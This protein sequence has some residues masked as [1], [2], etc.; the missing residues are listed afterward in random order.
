MNR[1]SITLRITLWY[2]LLMLAL[3]LLM[4][5]LL[6]GISDSILERDAVQRLTS[7]IEY[8]A[9]EIEYDDG[10]LEIDK[11]DFD[12]YKNG[13]TSLVYTDGH[14]LVA[15]QAPDG[16]P[17]DTAFEDAVTQRVTRDGQ[18]FFVYDRMVTFKKNP[19]VW[20]RGVLPLESIPGISGSILRIALI[21][22]PFLALLAAVGGY[23][24]TKHA[25]RPVREITR[26]VE[27]IT[28]GSDLSQRI[29]LGE[30]Q[31]EIH[32]LAD[33]FNAMLRRLEGAFEAEKQFVSNVSHELRTPVSV[34]LAQCEYALDAGTR[35]TNSEAQE[36]F[37]VIQRQGL[38][39]NRL[40]AHLLTITRL[41]QGS[42]RVAL[43]RTDVSE[44]VRSLSEEQRMLA[45]EHIAFRAEVQ[46]GLL[47]GVDTA[48]FARLYD[49]LVQNAF[50]YGRSAVCVTLERR[51]GAIALCVADDGEGILPEHQALIWRRFYQVNPSRTADDTGSMGLGLSIAKQIALLHHGDIALESVPGEGSRFCFTI[52]ER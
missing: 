3:V 6:L 21:A 49:N 20:I 5:A 35:E 11:D 23:W 50:R 33:T 44:L 40:I 24:I 34:I 36:G 28:E 14:M 16:F 42:F 2:A 27:S 32:A 48:L 51:N 4:L 8:N 46:P 13:V 17:A 31:D 12:Y 15:G 37:E 26:T 30:G 39:M 1:F 45:P 43:Q 19:A 18:S 7:V 25:F 47:A 22:L 41:E 10:E 9:E 29:A 52:A 38:R